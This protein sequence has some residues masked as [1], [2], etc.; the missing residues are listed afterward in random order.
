LQLVFV[1]IAVNFIPNKWSQALSLS[2]DCH[3]LF[4]IKGLQECSQLLELQIYCLGGRIMTAMLGYFFK[5]K[6]QHFPQY[7]DGFM[8][9]KQPN[10]YIKKHT[11][12]LDSV[13]QGKG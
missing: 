7:P 6:S 10:T 8:I 13:K 3:T 4:G 1:S 5:S 11:T 9:S 12:L 2:V